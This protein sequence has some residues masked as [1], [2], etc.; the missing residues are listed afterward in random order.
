MQKKTRK[1]FIAGNWKMNKTLN[2]AVYLLTE[3]SAMQAPFCDVAVCTPY[4]YISDAVR[5]LKDSCV[6]AG[7]QNI[8]E[9]EAGAYTGEISAAQL[10]SVGAQYV[11]IGHSERREYYNDTN[12][13]VNAKIKL[14][15]NHGLIPILCVGEDLSAREHGVLKE[16][17]AMQ[18]KLALLGITHSQLENIIIAYEPIWA[19]GTGKTATPDEAE[20]V[21]SFIRK[22]ISSIYSDESAAL[23]RILYGG[24]M[25]AKNAKELLAKENIDGGLIG[26]AALNCA[27]FLKIVEA[28]EQ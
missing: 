8:C 7:A 10:A 5:I 13:R 9:H 17:I 16:Y 18:I 3:L 11:I 23:I 20:E 12:E 4:L 2:E 19:I 22:V 21:C 26:G 14:A 15:L 28:C 1:K 24:S 6:K 25:N 27:D